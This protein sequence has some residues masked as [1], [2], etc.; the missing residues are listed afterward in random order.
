MGSKRDLGPKRASG[1]MATPSA[2]HPHADDGDDARQGMPIETM[3]G[4]RLPR[5]DAVQTQ[6][7]ALEA[8]CRRQ[9]IIRRIDAALARIESGEY[10]Y[11]QT[12][13]GPIAQA[14]LE[15]EPTVATCIR[16]AGSGQ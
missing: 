12:C 2:L 11:C 7:I 16:C 3:T 15:N 13:G 14:R 8:E 6:T 10:G 9:I 1:P 4:G 5:M